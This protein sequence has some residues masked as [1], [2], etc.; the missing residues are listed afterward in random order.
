MKRLFGI[1]V[2]AL[3]LLT[4]D[5]CAARGFRRFGPP[6]PRPP[7]REA[8]MD[9]YDSGRVWEAGHYRWTGHRYRWVDGRWVKLPRRS[10]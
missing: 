1:G 5:A 3:A 9:R 2:I 6:P 4:M 8:M 7:R 10:R